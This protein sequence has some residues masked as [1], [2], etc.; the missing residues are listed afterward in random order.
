MAPTPEQKLRKAFKA[1]TGDVKA[2]LTLL[3]HAAKTL[4]GEEFGRRVADLS[5]K[6]EMRND[7]ARRFALE[8][9]FNGRPLKRVTHGE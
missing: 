6:L 9:D 2:F 3:D 4:R 8:L 7:L 5:N 1:H